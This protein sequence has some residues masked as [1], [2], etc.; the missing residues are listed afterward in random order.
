[1]LLDNTLQEIYS[2]TEE[3]LNNANRILRSYYKVTFKKIFFP[4]L[5]SPPPVDFSNIADWSDKTEKFVEN[6]FP[7]IPFE[8]SYYFL[9][10]WEEAISSGLEM[11]R[12]LGIRG[13]QKK[14]L[15]T[16]SATPSAFSI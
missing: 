12:F 4:N 5:L 16:K 13:I 10:T 14:L 1:M 9:G 15:R 7:C 3:S 2:T 11:L 6:N 8:K